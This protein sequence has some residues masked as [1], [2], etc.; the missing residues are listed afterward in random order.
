M[1]PTFRCR[2]TR[3]F[4]HFSSTPGSPSASS[5]RTTAT[6]TASDRP[7][8]NPAPCSNRHPSENVRLPPATAVQTRPRR[9]RPAVCH[10]AASSAPW[11]SRRLAR[12]SSSLDV[13]STWSVTSTA[14]AGCSG[15]PGVPGGRMTSSSLAAGSSGALASGG[16]TSKSMDF[17]RR[18]DCRRRRGNRAWR[19]ADSRGRGRV[20]ARDR[21]FRPASATAKRGRASAPPSRRDLRRNGMRRPKAGAATRNPEE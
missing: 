17:E 4:G 18:A 1:P 12:R 8:T 21:P 2:W 20:R 9:P 14:I 6:P 5:A 16:A 3:S 11:M 15:M 10:S 7:A 19:A 13:E